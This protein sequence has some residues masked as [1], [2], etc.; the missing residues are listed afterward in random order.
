MKR[1]NHDEIEDDKPKTKEEINEQKL[2]GDIK[3]D[4]YDENNPASHEYM[5]FHMKDG[6]KQKNIYAYKR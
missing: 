6:Q 3:N 4:D 1:L 2:M 5:F